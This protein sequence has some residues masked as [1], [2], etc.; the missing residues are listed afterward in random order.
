MR[1]S[2]EF[3]LNGPEPVVTRLLVIPGAEGAGNRA[4][5][6]V[7]CGDIM[8]LGIW[9]F[10]NCVRPVPVAGSPVVGSKIG[11]GYSLRSQLPGLPNPHVLSTVA[12]GI[13]YWLVMPC[14]CRVPW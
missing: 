11:N 9:L 8:V 14:C 7:A 2:N 1:V 13:V 3:W 10:R 6:A 4:S 5:M 12:V